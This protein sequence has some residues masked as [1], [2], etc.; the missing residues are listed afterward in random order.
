MGCTTSKI[1]ETDILA[2]MAFT[3]ETK[4]NVVALIYFEAWGRASP[5]MFILDYCK[6]PFEL[7]SITMGGYINGGWKKYEKLPAL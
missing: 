4:A 2:Q 1:P 6:I 3:K 7:K 5:I